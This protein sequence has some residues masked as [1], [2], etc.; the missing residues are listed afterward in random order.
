MKS[1]YRAPPNM[2]FTD[3]TVLSFNLRSAASRKDRLPSPATHRKRA[4]SISLAV[5]LAYFGCHAALGITMKLVP[6]VATL[7]AL[8]TLAIGLCFAMKALRPPRLVTVVSYLMTAEVLW[9]MTGAAVFWE[10]GKYATSAILLLWLLRRRPPRI[11]WLALVYLCLLI[12]S[13]LTTCSQISDFD[14]LRQ[15]ISESFSGPFALAVCIFSFYELELE[16]ADLQQ[17]L[18]AMLGPLIGVAAICTFS[19]ASLGAGYEFGRQSN[20]DITGGFGPNQVSAMLGLGMLVAFLWMQLQKPQASLR[21]VAIGLILYFFSQA[22]L[23]FSRTGVY[24]GIITIVVASAFALRNRRQFL[25][26]VASLAVLFALGYFLVFPLLDK[27][28]GGM[29]TDRFSQKGFSNREDI[30]RGDL[31]LALRNPVLGVGLGQVKH[32]RESQLGIGGAAH[33]EFTRLLAEH[34]MLGALALGT[35][36]LM[37]FQVLAR[38]TSR[39]NKAWA[40]SLIAYALLFMLVSG[41]RLAAPAVAMGLAMVKFAVA[42][43]S[44]TRR[45]TKQHVSIHTFGYRSK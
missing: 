2:T 1:D 17:V 15:T 28:T 43:A 20:S 7:H 41:M 3:H 13:I 25:Y 14:E 24:L 40:M 16:A 19:T 12:P 4:T 32:V 11:C 33:T 38:S 22:A 31:E 10:Y 27:F 26:G 6:A 36:I 18:L 23:T 37:A 34:G 5:L 35:L 21:L 30:A 29:L 42:G 44:P 45:R 39:L 8:L 9:R